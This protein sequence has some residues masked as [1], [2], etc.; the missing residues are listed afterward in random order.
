[1]GTGPQ[2]DG[3]CQWGQGKAERNVGRCRRP[4]GGRCSERWGGAQE[5]PAKGVTHCSSSHLR[6]PHNPQTGC[7]GW[8]SQCRSRPG[9]GTRPHHRLSLEQCPPR[10]VRPEFSLCGPGGRRTELLAH[11]TCPGL[12]QS[13]LNQTPRGPGTKLGQGRVGQELRYRWVMPVRLTHC[14]RGSHQN[15]P[16]SRRPRCTTACWTHSAHCCTGG[17][18]SCSGGS[19]QME[20]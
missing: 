5:V 2:G 13:A 12:S 20:E 19:L 9:S 16:H 1:M 8:S 14:C 4:E 6:H 18:S 7:S 17:K 15:H 10:T 3:G 11:S